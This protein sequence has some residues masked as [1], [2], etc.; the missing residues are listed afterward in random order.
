MPSRCRGGG[1][2]GG[3]GGGG[4]RREPSITSFT[5]GPEALRGFVGGHRGGGGCPSGGGAAGGGGA[6]GVAA[7]ALLCADRGRPIEAMRPLFAAVGLVD[8]RQFFSD[9]EAIRV[10]ERYVAAAAAEGGG[11][12]RSGTWASLLCDALFKGG[13]K[14]RGAA[15]DVNEQGARKRFVGCL[16][17]DARHGRPPTSH[18][19]ARGAAAWSSR[20]SSGGTTTLLS[21]L[22]VYALDPYVLRELSVLCGATANVGSTRSRAVTSQRRSS[23]SRGCGPDNG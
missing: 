13:A 23:R 3:G 14:R 4:R 9:A 19:K 21:E 1:K 2:S 6:P 10:L 5:G 11:G 16:E 22:N 12:R 8:N 7:A 15:A 20:P 18:C 17:K